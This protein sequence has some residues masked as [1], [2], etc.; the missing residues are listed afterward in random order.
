MVYIKSEGSVLIN[1]FTI[2]LN[3]VISVN[4][5]NSHFMISIRELKQGYRAVGTWQAAQK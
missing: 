2:S 3:T 5:G 4:L 1:L